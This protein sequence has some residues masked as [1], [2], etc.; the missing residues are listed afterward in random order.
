MI[1]LRQLAAQAGHHLDVTLIEREARMS[2]SREAHFGRYDAMS[3]CIEAA[4][5][6]Q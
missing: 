6:R 2:A 3:R 1:F 4:I 5:A